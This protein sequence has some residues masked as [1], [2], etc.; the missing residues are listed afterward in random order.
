[1][2]SS[3]FNECIELRIHT[4]ASRLVVLFFLRF[5]SQEKLKHNNANVI[6]MPI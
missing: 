6:A 1:M 3:N 4:E 5:F 2:Y